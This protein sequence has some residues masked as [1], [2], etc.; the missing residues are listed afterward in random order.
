M[1]KGQSCKWF[2]L[3]LS[4]FLSYQYIVSNC[5]MTRNVFCGNTRGPTGCISFLVQRAFVCVV[6]AFYAYDNSE[7]CAKLPQINH[8]SDL[9]MYLTP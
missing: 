1:H 6:M 5:Y 7:V 8:K 2:Q 3:V 9:G 4:R